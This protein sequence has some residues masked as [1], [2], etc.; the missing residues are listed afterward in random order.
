MYL[1]TLQQNDKFSFETIIMG[2]KNQHANGRTEEKLLQ[3][4]LREQIFISKLFADGRQQLLIPTG[5]LTPEITRD[6]LMRKAFT[7]SD[8]VSRSKILRH[9]KLKCHKTVFHSLLV[10]VFLEHSLMSLS[11]DYNILFNSLP[12]CLQPTLLTCNIF[13]TV[14]CLIQF[15]NHHS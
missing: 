4:F 13:D 15:G 9:H 11:T 10:P 5:P 1:N 8:D 14:P 12:C 7:L 3:K 6:N 2:K